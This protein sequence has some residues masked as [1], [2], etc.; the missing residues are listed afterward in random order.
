MFNC[1]YSSILG[2]VLVVNAPI[3][4]SFVDDKNRIIN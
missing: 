4:R 2:C 3:H 1:V